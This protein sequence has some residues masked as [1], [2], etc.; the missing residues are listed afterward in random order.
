MTADQIKKAR[1]KLKLTQAQF[2]EALGTTQGRISALEHGV[3]EISQA[4]AMAIEHL[5]CKRKATK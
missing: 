3:R 1:T 2:A 4:E 5:F